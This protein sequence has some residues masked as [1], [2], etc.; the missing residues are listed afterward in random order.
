[1]VLQFQVKTKNWKFSAFFHKWFLIED[2][3][4]LLYLIHFVEANRI[5]KELRLFKILYKI[6]WIVK[7]DYII[8]P[9]NKKNQW[10][11][12]IK[13]WDKDE[14]FKA[15]SIYSSK[16]LIY[17]TKKLNSSGFFQSP[18]NLFEVFKDF[19]QYMPKEEL[20]K[21]LFTTLDI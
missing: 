17:M 3:F 6:P 5:S 21:Q 19:L 14:S 12:I 15:P 2:Y 4:L 8:Q 7:W 13:W 1:M 20:N 10:I 9:K 16:G 11:I 18:N